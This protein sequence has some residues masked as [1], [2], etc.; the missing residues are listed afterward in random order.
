MKTAALIAF[1]SA[2]AILSVAVKN[3]LRRGESPSGM[4]QIGQAIPDFTLPDRTGQYFRFRQTANGHKL[5]IVNFWASWCE[6]CRL[7]MPSLE[8][9][10]KTKSKDGLL[11]LAINEDEQPEALETYLKEKPV[12]FPVLLDADG[13]LMKQLGGRAFPTT[14]LVGSDGR[15][16]MVFE[17]VQEYLPFMVDGYLT[18]R[19]GKQ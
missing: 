6:P 8:K 17:G 2:F 7:E 18:G 15:V 9:M 10:Y 19:N 14:I 12:S 4:L 13:A 16:Q 11:I 5:V 1:F 3:E